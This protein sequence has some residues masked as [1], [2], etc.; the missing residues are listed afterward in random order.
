MRPSKEKPMPKP[1][2]YV[3]RPLYHTVAAVNLKALSD[4]L[5]AIL[6]P[7]WEFF[8]KFSEH[9]LSSGRL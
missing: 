3:S 7:Y 9:F 4:R 8:R 1:I 2:H 5:L 6:K